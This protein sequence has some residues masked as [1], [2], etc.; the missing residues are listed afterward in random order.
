MAIMKAP[1]VLLFERKKCVCGAGWH[2][3]PGKGGSE[4]VLKWP[5]SVALNFAVFLVKM[6]YFVGSFVL[7]SLFR[8]GETAGKRSKSET[9][10][11]TSALRSMYFDTFLYCRFA[12]SV[13]FICKL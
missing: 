1:L 9:R 8:Y 5:I 2:F 7:A 12:K 6:K 10:E 4:R 11:P 13:G 3:R